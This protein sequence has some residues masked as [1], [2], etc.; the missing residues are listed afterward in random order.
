MP[1]L[2]LITII[3]GFALSATLDGTA[4]GLA[5]G[6]GVCFAAMLGVTLAGNVL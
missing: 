3:S 1:G 4:A 5:L 6:S 2:M